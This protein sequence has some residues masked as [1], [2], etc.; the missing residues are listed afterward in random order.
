MPAACRFRQPGGSGQGQRGDADTG[1]GCPVCRPCPGRS[2]GAEAYRSVRSGC[3]VFRHARLATPR[4]QERAR[5]GEGRRPARCAHASRIRARPRTCGYRG[6]PGSARV[7]RTRKRL[8]TGPGRA[9]QAARVRRRGACGPG[10][11][12]PG[13]SGTGPWDRR[14]RAPVRCPHRR[15]AAGPAGRRSAAPSSLP[16]Q[17]RPNRRW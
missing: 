12:H 3:S 4:Y 9:C 15:R 11:G 5:T 1:C 13:C 16:V 8:H 14:C 6:R 2:G 17:S 10:C 7:A